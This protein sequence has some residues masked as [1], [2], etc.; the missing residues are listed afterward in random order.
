MFIPYRVDV[1]MQRYPFAN[2]A[3]IAVT[4]VVSIAA[5]NGTDEDFIAL[6]L[7]RDEDFRLHGLLTHALVH[8][9]IIHL[10]GNMFFLF[11]FG[12]AVNARLG[13]LTY[14]ALY[15]TAAVLAG[16]AWM[17]FDRAPVE[18]LPG[19]S[20]QIDTLV[21]ASG[22]IMGVVGAFLIL[23]P[24]NDVSVVW[25]VSVFFG[26]TF[27][28]SSYWLIAMYVAF[29]VWGM[30][31][32]NSNVAYLSHLTGVVVGAGAVGTLVYLSV[33]APLASEENL[34]QMLG[35]RPKTDDDVPLPSRAYPAMPGMYTVHA[36]DRASGFTTTF[37]VQARSE[38]EARA[39]SVQED[40]VIIRIDP[41]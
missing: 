4:M 3:I 33:I 9:G 35:L 8:G 25:G 5:F 17:M 12:N 40:L 26:G 36:R 18:I 23:Y 14:L 6:A 1:P 24:R 2:W 37:K 16:L 39:K 19:I 41:P 32:G 29:D 21:G 34:L 30:V 11:L 7:N 31:R 28:M 38:A 20:I 22:A 10:L 27:Q 13:H 15:A